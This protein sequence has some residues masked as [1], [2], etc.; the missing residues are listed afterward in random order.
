MRQCKK[1]VDAGALLRSSVSSKTDIL[2]VGKQDLSV[3]GADGMS[4]KHEKALEIN[5]SGKGSVKII[6]ETEFIAMLSSVP[7]LNIN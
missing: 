3:V 6:N 4:A 7:E 1:A 2:V 5:T